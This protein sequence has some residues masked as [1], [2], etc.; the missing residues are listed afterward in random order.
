MLINHQVS[1]EAS[2]LILVD[3]ITENYL[4]LLETT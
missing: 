2:E 1:F 4:V 3:P